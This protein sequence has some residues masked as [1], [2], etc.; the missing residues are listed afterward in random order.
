MSIHIG[1]TRATK[2]PNGTKPLFFATTGGDKLVFPNALFRANP[3]DVTTYVPMG[4]C[5]QVALL[6]G[7]SNR[8]FDVQ[9][10]EHDLHL[11][12]YDGWSACIA[13]SSMHVTWRYRTELKLLL[14]NVVTVG[15][16]YANVGGGNAF[17]V[18]GV[19][20]AVGSTWAAYDFEFT[21]YLA[22]G[23]AWAPCIKGGTGYV[24]ERNAFVT[25]TAD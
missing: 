21:G 5:Q 8:L 23:G 22:A 19:D 2:F 11:T 18:N 12:S 10:S 4:A 1:S 16:G 15:L 9:D 13:T 25:I 6:P 17:Y 20:I 14:N 3:G 24:A 7:T